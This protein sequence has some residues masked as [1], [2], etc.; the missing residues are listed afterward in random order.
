VTTRPGRLAEAARAGKGPLG[1]EIGFHRHWRD[2]PWDQGRWPNFQPAEFA[3]RHCGQLY[4]DSRI[5]DAIQRVRAYMARPLRI[6]SAHRCSVHNR[7]VGGAAHS[8]HLRLALDVD[9]SDM[10]ER[11]R[12]RLFARCREAGFD[13]F[14]FYATFLHVDDRSGRRWWTEKGKETWSFLRA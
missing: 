12:R 3:C 13:A 9:A 7:R 2:A 5:F 10:D 8:R 4:F 1:H 6:N 14:G 11:Q